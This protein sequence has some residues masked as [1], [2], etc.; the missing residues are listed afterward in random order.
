M[1]EVIV[2]QDLEDDDVRAPLAA[3]PRRLEE[4]AV[5]Q[6]ERLRPQLAGAVRPA[7]RAEHDDERE[8]AARSSE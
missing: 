6:R 3:H 5:A 7:E 1:S 2:G 8:Q 4:V